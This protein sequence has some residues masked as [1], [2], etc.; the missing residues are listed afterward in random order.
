VNGQWLVE[1][2]GLMTSLLSVS[3]SSTLPLW[4]TCFIFFTE[5][6]SMTRQEFWEWMLTCPA[7]E[8]ADPSGWFLADDMGDECR[9]FFYFDE[10][11]DDE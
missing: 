10:E 1:T 3:L 7:K 6:I 9:V 2:L 5:E 4:A 8:N 11:H